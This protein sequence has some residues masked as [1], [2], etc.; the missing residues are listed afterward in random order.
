VV[1]ATHEEAARQLDRALDIGLPTTV[2]RQLEEI[3]LEVWL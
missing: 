1:G 3:G 2:G